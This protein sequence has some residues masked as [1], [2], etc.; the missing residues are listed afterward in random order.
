[1][2]FNSV[3]RCSYCLE[4]LDPSYHAKTTFV[5]RVGYSS[6]GRQYHRPCA[7]LPAS[8][9]TLEPGVYCPQLIAMVSWYPS[10]V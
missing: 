3:V 5:R 10:T 6:R 2:R 1:M 4:A 9:V 8:D 7:L